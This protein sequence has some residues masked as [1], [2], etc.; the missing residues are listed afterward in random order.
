M[1]GGDGEGRWK[2]RGGGG[3]ESAE[4]WRAGG[5]YTTG[6]ESE[7]KGGEGSTEMRKGG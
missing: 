4:D 5:R 6:G 2:M 7:G 1:R 3:S